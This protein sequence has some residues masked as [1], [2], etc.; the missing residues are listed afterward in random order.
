MKVDEERKMRIYDFI[1]YLISSARGLLVE[2]QVYGPFRCLDAV[3]R[4]IHL[5]SDLG[6]KDPYLDELKDEVDKGKYLLLIDESKFKD[7]IIHLNVKLAR[8]IKEDLNL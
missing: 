8:K 6:I 5:L 7:F 1:A 3:S 2:P 4:F